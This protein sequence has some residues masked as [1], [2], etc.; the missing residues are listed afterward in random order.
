MRTPGFLRLLAS[1][2]YDALLA[3]ALLFVATF[4][5]VLLFGEATHAPRRYFLQIT[6]WGIAGLYF[7]WCWSRG[8]TLAMQAWKL[9]LVDSVGQ[10]ISPLRAMQRYVLATLGLFAGGAGFLWALVDRD[11]RYL[12]DRLLGTRLVMVD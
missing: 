2:F 3:V 6:L 11:R 4:I 9:R 8:R 1:F 12:H 7:A 5:F 10:P